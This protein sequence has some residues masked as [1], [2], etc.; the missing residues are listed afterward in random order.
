MAHMEMDEERTLV[1]GQISSRPH[2]TGFPQRVVNSKGNPRLFHGNLG[3]GEI[4]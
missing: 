3:V 1:S 2:T 4:L